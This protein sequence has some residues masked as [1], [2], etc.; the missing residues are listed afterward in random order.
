MDVALRIL[1]DVN[2][3]ARVGPH[4]GCEIAF[5]VARW[6]ICQIA[7]ALA[8]DDLIVAPT[9][10]CK[11][12]EECLLERPLRASVNAEVW[13]CAVAIEWRR[14]KCAFAEVDVVVYL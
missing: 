6:V 11:R 8:D 14:S 12:R 2:Y 9:N 3:Y 13:I 10:R 1:V 4:I 5:N 7:A